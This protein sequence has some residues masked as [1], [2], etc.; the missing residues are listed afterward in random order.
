[1][2]RHFAT[3]TNGCI[4]FLNV[5]LF[6]SLATLPILALWGI[7]FSVMSPAGNLIF[8]P[9]LTVF[10]LCA[11]LIFFTELLYI[12]NGWLVKIL[13]LVTSFWSW[14][15]SWSSKTWL[16]G[17]YK[18]L[19]G[20]TL[21]LA[22]IALIM[23]HHKHWGKPLSNALTLIILSCSALLLALCK[24]SD[25]S[26]ELVCGRKKVLII[27]KQGKIVVDDRGALALKRSPEDWI[28]FTL[29]PALIQKTGNCK[30]DHV[31]VH[32]PARS[33]F[34]G[35]RALTERIPVKTVALPFFDTQKSKGG[36]RSFFAL[37]STARS[38][39][40]TLIRT[41]PPLVA[42]S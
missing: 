33:T 1:M 31:I 2:K 29:V 35:L 34:E 22:L 15:L 30:V 11:S 13:E 10:L 36:W 28:N 16:V 6:I 14:C 41:K 20:A 9:F 40:V 8:N 7:P 3:F 5:Q 39:K 32:N 19:A 4:Q 21:L 27:S 18:P 38:E 23:A 12:P 26:F 25:T 42:Q 17:F 24:S 37:R